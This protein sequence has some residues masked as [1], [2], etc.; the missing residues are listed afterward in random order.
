MSYF[1]DGLRVLNVSPASRS[2]NVFFSCLFFVE[3]GQIESGI[4]LGDGTQCHC[5]FIVI[6][7]ESVGKTYLEGMWL[8]VRKFFLNKAQNSDKKLTHGGTK[9]RLK[10]NVMTVGLH[11]RFGSMYT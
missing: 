9:S 5:P 1:G 2:Q 6:Q 4:G 8:V 3:L 7:K 11:T 10:C